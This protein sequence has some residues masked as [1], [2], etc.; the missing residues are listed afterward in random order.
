MQVGKVLRNFPIENEQEVVLRTPRREDLDGLLELINSLV[1]EK[2]EISRTERVTIEEE[3]QWLPGMLARLEKDEIFFLV[4]IVDRKLIA[5]ADVQILHGDEKHVG[6]IG[7]VVRKDLRGLG[8]GTK[9]VEVLSEQAEGLGLKVL[10]LNVF[11]TNKHAIHVYEKGG[12]VQTGTIP[13]K[14]FRSGR[15]IDELIMTKLIE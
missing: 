8:I 12:F 7:I 10:T 6:V 13:K 3:A 14:H 15:Y 9:M 5:S 2:A 11:A 1:E 4:A